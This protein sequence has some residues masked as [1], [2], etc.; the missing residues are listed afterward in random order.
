[1][2]SVEQSNYSDSKFGFPSCLVH[3]DL[4]TPNVL[5]EQDAQGQPTNKLCAIIDWQTVHAG[6]PCEDICRVLSLNTSG[7]YRRQV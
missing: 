3:A 5:W 4:W 6:N 2:S 7:T 1:V